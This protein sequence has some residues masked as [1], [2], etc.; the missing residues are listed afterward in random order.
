MQYTVYE[1]QSG[2]FTIEDQNG[3]HAEVLTD[4]Y[5]AHILC[6]QLNRENRIE[7]AEYYFKLYHE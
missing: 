6:D 7:A 3:D 5:E 4:E 2:V 1:D